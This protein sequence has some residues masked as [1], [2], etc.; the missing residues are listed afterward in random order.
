[1]V[2]AFM[3]ARVLFPW[4]SSWG[5]TITPHPA[6]DH[7]G[8]PFRSPPL[9]PLRML[10]GLLGGH[11]FGERGPDTSLRNQGKIVRGWTKPEKVD[12]MY[13]SA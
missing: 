9:S 6:G 4:L 1:M 10:M 3:V 8:P 12:K 7:K 2:W 11:F 5:N 13:F